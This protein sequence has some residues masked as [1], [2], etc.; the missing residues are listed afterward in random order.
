MGR[1]KEALGLVAPARKMQAGSGPKSGCGRLTRQFPFGPSREF[2]KWGSA[3]W[4]IM[5]YCRM[6]CQEVMFRIQK[7]SFVLSR[8]YAGVFFSAKSGRSIGCQ[9]SSCSSQYLH[10]CSGVTTL[11][12]KKTSGLRGLWLQMLRGTKHTNEQKRIFWTSDSSFC[13]HRSWP[14]PEVT[15]LG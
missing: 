1:F 10:L 12:L 13:F 8:L 6:P 9:A 2:S 5:W 11:D 15:L 4:S 3:S 14:S 7:K